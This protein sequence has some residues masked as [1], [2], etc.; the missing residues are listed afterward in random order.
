MRLELADR[1]GHACVV[2]G[3]G[4]EDLHRREQRLQE[5]VEV[6]GDTPGELADRLQLLVLPQVLLDA[7]P[8]ADV[9]DHDQDR[10]RTAVGERDRRDLDV[11][12]GP[13]AAQELLLDRRLPLALLLRGARA[14][15][16][17]VPEVGMDQVEHRRADEVFGRVVAQHVRTAL[18]REDDAPPR[19]DGDP[20]GRELDQGAVAPL[21]LG[22]CDLG[23]LPRGD[24]LDGALVVQ[25]AAGFVAHRPG[26]FAHPHAAAVASPPLRLEADHDAL[27]LD[28]VDER[29]AGEVRSV[30]GV[31]DVHRGQ[32]GVAR[33]AEHPHQRRIGHVHPTLRGGAV[34][35][36]DR[37][38]EDAAKT[39]LGLA[40]R[41][42]GVPAL[43]D[44]HRDSEESGDAGRPETER[45]LRGLEELDT[46]IGPGDDL[47]GY[48]LGPP[49]ADHLEVVLVK[50]AGLVGGR[51][52]I[53]VG[54]ADQGIGGG[55]ERSRYGLV[56]EEE[57]ALLVLG[58][59]E[60]RD[61]ID[62]LPEQA[63]AVA[64]R[65]LGSLALG[66]VGERDRRWPSVRPSRTTG[67]SLTSTQILRP[68]A[69]TSS[70]S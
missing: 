55:P 22:Q 64:Q 29:L 70:S 15:G 19:V 2:G 36:D 68:R 67:A 7:Q 47:L 41:L 39:L 61:E 62:R 27:A 30:P 8:F 10:G 59:D 1:G 24:V 60:V 17:D 53:G 43:G 34:H 54:L 14:A 16:H 44:V 46:A 37:V 65:S 6:V 9:V 13:V 48:E 49:A 51:R 52:E 26:G 69:P 63:F 21:A 28:A 50:V 5:V 20:V 33:V 11:D 25:R 57:P 56:G 40:Q 35:A 4:A 32:L 58:E 12:H 38:L 42:L 45:N 23:F 31:G 66:D 18:V 3:A